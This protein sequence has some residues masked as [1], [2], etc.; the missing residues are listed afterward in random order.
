M[1]SLADLN[2]LTMTPSDYALV[3]LGVSDPVR[4]GMLGTSPDI[5]ESLDRGFPAVRER[6]AGIELTQGAALAVFHGVPDLAVGPD[7]LNYTVPRD[8]FIHTDAR[9]VVRLLARQVDGQELPAWI[10]FDGNT[11]LFHGRPAAG[12]GMPHLD[13]ELIARDNA[14][15]EARTRFSIDDAQRSGLARLETGEPGFEVA[16][17]SPEQLAMAPGRSG[18][19]LVPYVPIRDQRHLAGRPL[20]FRVPGDAFAHTNPHAVVR[21]SATL[22]SGE[23]LPSWLAFDR[24]GGRFS[25][26]PPDDFGG[27]LDVRIVARD[28]HG[29]EAVTHVKLSF[30]RSPVRTAGGVDHAQVE[31]AKRSA[32]SFGDQLRQLRQPAGEHAVVDRALA[33]RPA[34]DSG[35]KNGGLARAHRV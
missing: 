1:P 27:T 11:G 33:T 4:V 3:R 23:P 9:A 14:G 7:G 19:L 29:L 31:P 13:V 15:R 24:V 35:A 10:S 25:G 21:L 30:V 8:A 6:L 12:E 28:D 34:S 20:D 26:T 18:E 16:R 17:L 2:V 32:P 5:L 22:A